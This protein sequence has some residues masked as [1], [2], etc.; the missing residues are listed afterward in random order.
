MG[1]LAAVL[2]S[3]FLSEHTNPASK[4][5]TTW[6]GCPFSVAGLILSDSGLGSSL[7]AFA[8]NRRELAHIDLKSFS[9]LNSNELF[10]LLCY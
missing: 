7:D 1:F 8:S 6:S 10:A 2:P 3:Q 5:L 4:R 9:A